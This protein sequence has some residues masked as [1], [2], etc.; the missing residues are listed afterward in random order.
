[1]VA[2]LFIP[3]ILMA[4]ASAQNYIINGSA[5]FDGATG[6]LTH[7]PSEVGNRRTWVLEMLF[8]RSA[9]GITQQLFTARTDGNNTHDLSIQSNGKLFWQ[10]YDLGVAT[11]AWRFDANFVLN[12]S[13]AYYHLI[14]AVDTTHATAV[15]R[16]RAFLNGV[17]LTDWSV[18]TQPSLNYESAVGVNT[19]NPHRIGNNGGSTVPNDF[20]DGYIARVALYDGL[21]ITDPASAGMGELTTDGYWR[22]KDV[23][24]LNLDRKV[25][26]TPSSSSSY[27]GNTGAFTIGSGTLDRGTGAN[28]AIL[29][30]KELIGDFELSFTWDT[31]T[32]N[33]INFLIAPTTHWDSSFDQNAAYAGLTY[34]TSFM[35]NDAIGIQCANAN[36]IAVFDS[37][38]QTNPIGN[39]ATNDRIKITRVGSLFRLYKNETLHRTINTTLSTEQM[40]VAYAT[41]SG[42]GMN[43]SQINE[44]STEVG[45]YLNGNT[46]ILDGQNC[47]TGITSHT[48]GTGYTWDVTHQATATAVN[49]RS[50][51][52]AS[53]GIDNSFGASRWQAADNQSTTGWYQ[54]DFGANN[55]K[56][57]RKF[58]IYHLAG[59]STLDTFDL[60]G[61]DTGTFSGEETTIQ[62]GLD[63]GIGSDAPAGAWYEVTFSNGVSY[64]YY[65]LEF[66]GVSTNTTNP[67]RP[68]ITE[69][70][71]MEVGRPA[72]DKTGTITSTNDSP[73]DSTSQKNTY[74]ATLNS[75]IPG[76]QVTLSEGNM[77]SLHGPDDATALTLPL[78]DGIDM[79]VEV[80]VVTNPGANVAGVAL[81]TLDGFYGVT[82]WGLVNFHGNLATE[83]VYQSGG[84]IRNNS[85]LTTAGATYTSGDIIGIRKDA[86]G[87]ITFYKNGSP[88]GGN[89]SYTGIAEDL[90]VA[91]ANNASSTS[92]SEFRIRTN[93]DDWT[94]SYGDAVGVST[95]TIGVGN[96][97]TLNPLDNIAC[98]GAL[99]N[100]NRTV[101]TGSSEYGPIVATF[102][103]EASTADHFWTVTVDAKSGAG[104]WHIIG[105]INADDT[106]SSTQQ[107]GYTTNGH[108]YYG[109]NGNYL[110]SNNGAGVSYGAT[111]AV[112]DE[113]GVSLVAG[114]LKFYKW[115]G[116]AWSDQGIAATGLSGVFLPA[117]G[118][119]VNNETTT[120]TI[121]F[122]P[123]DW[124]GA[125]PNTEKPL[126]TQNMPT[127]GVNP[128]EHVGVILPS[129]DGTGPKTFTGFGFDPD[130][131]IAKGRNDT[132]NWFWAD[133]VRG[134]NANIRSDSTAAEANPT[135][136]FANGG[137]GSVTTDGFTAVAGTSN[138]NN[139]NGSGINYFALGLKAGG[140]AVANNDGTIAA[141][142]SANP[143]LGFSIVTATT[144]SSGD[145]VGHGLGVKPGLIIGKRLNGTSDWPVYH[146]DVGINMALKLNT[147]QAAFVSSSYWTAEPTNT[148]FNVGSGSDVLGP[149]VFYC[150]AE[151][152]IIKIS[153]Y[154]G[155]GSTDGPFSYY[156]GRPLWELS[157]RT[158]ATSNWHLW[159]S[160]R[161][162]VNVM[163]KRLFPNLSALEAEN[164]EGEI[165]FASTG[166]KIRDTETWLNANGGT[167]IY[168]AILDQF[169]PGGVSQVDQGRGR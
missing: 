64:R 145:T 85:V 95:T 155:N 152:D 34:L 132:N 150:F 66:T 117:I 12:D 146:K 140:P 119:W 29:S 105:I 111:Y 69:L 19:T 6:Y 168:L 163:D 93:Q 8:K 23:S 65:R 103:V 67:H 21:A 77:R 33:Q 104:E 76:S 136:D 26:F 44:T 157:K 46:F 17:Q 113:I 109:F 38:G 165:D 72:F 59:L 153:S 143:T 16:C 139:L 90:I 118:D 134:A 160:V 96:F 53:Q 101:V 55:A 100:G 142:V 24:K 169:I 129:G 30:V 40:K 121:R 61:S 4:G 97:P 98:A 108:G 135:T 1:M 28:V 106:L 141:Q 78:V 158:D 42:Y 43:I 49:T 166:R 87:N 114:T 161:D 99:S 10:D 50:G 133:S 130:L 162:P 127:I 56:D 126:A 107:L 31:T 125:A 9:L 36:T 164:G 116:S 5:L 13:G 58:R 94:Y 89:P 47:A 48:D 11:P 54:L 45:G 84:T 14:L 32:A 52:P 51:Y 86:S 79:A 115:N 18:E 74:F 7:T 92:G 60:K 57:L 154:T 112:G 71:A 138:T 124:A 159:D 75:D 27:I 3:P 123:N 128:A 68:N 88:T 144:V 73:T 80:E 102:G 22:I 156:G 70:E 148:V 41:S 20:F 120:F 62:T 25:S 151:T 147:T 137:I 2:S 167:Y 82:D 91:I 35:N 110:N 83:Y 15:N 81:L 39:L 131:V 63:F 149:M 122:D 37:V